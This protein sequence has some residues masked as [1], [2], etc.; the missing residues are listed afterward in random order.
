MSEETLS[1]EELR[2]RGYQP[3][4][5]V[6]KLVEGQGRTAFLGTTRIALFK[7]EDAIYAIKNACPHAG[8]SLSMGELR[9]LVVTCPRHDWR[10]H[11]GSGA[12]LN[13]K[14]FQARTWPTLV[15]HGQVWLQ[16]DAA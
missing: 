2:Q 8:A 10:F 12:C 7:I 3:V 14:M 15:A 4:C 9:G 11:V 16:G 13:K 1:Q 6:E 5:A